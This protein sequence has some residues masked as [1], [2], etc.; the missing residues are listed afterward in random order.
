[1]DTHACM[2]IYMHIYIHIHTACEVL[3]FCDA[4]VSTAGFAGKSSRTSKDGGGGDREEVNLRFHNLEAS[5]YSSSLSLPSSIPYSFDVID[6]SNLSDHIGL[7]NI[8]VCARPLLY[9]SP[10]SRLCMEVMVS[11]EKE[12]IHQM[13]NDR[14]CLPH[15]SLAALILG[16]VP[17]FSSEPFRLPSM[18]AANVAKMLGASGFHTRFAL[19]LAGK[20]AADEELTISA[21]SSLSLPSSSSSSS[22]TPSHVASLCPQVAMTPEQL[23]DIMLPM[24]KCMFLEYDVIFMRQMYRGM[25]CVHRTHQCFVCHTHTTYITSFFVLIY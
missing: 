7:I 2:H 23:A 20:T 25:T 22:S 6:T 3:N 24:Y 13:L 8:I 5:V 16:M 9:P 15:A 21:P 19:K 14:L 10:H 18:S 1:M 17:A 11:G 4:L 12:N